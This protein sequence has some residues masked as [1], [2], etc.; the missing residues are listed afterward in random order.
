MNMY[1]TDELL[2]QYLA[3]H[4]GDSYFGVG[5]YPARC[6]SICLEV[7]AGRPKRRALDLGCAVGRTTFEL[8]RAFE[9][10]DGV[11][12]SNRFIDTANGLRQTGEMPYFLR[13]QGELG[14]QKSVSLEDAQLK[15]AATR[16]RFAVADACNLGA[17]FSGYDLVFAGNLIDRL[18]DPRAFLAHVHQLL[19]ADGVLVISSPYTLLEEFTPRSQWVG[20]FDRNGEPYRVLDGM[21][22]ILAAHFEPLQKPVDVPFVIRETA[23]KYQHSIAELT[24]WQ[25]KA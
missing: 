10:V 13:E 6:A 19:A 5:N 25:R 14:E 9:F 17:E 18:Q 8:A 12:L 21:S 20:G 3:F 11:D 23:R 2:G 4:F 16:T 22:E 24:A 7:M 1:E 15:D